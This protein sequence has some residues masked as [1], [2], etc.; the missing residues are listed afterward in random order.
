[1]STATAPASNFLA[2]APKAKLLLSMDGTIGLHHVRQQLG[3]QII[4]TAGFGG[5]HRRPDEFVAPLLV[6][7]LQIACASPRGHRDVLGRQRRH[8]GDRQFPDTISIGGVYKAE[9]GT[10]RASDYASSFDSFRFQNHPNKREVHVPE[11]CGLCGLRPAAT[12]IALPIPA[13]RELDRGRGGG[14]FPDKDETGKTDGWGVFSGTSAACPMAAGVVA[15]VLQKHPNATLA[16]VRQRLY[17]AVDVTAG[18]SSHGDSAG[19]GYDAATGYG[20]VDAE[21]AVA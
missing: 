14:S 11:V 13:G 19:P 5:R 2:V 3:V 16:E 4:S 10:L 7:G 17:K 21:Q 18:Q 8:V 15:L 1:M 6:A 20:L 9:D 12:Y